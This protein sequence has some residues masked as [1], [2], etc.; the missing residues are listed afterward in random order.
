ML[1]NYTHLDFANIKKRSVHFAG[2][3]GWIGG[4]RLCIISASQ[5]HESCPWARAAFELAA[6]RPSNSR[7]D[8]RLQPLMKRFPSA[9]GVP[10]AVFVQFPYDLA[11][12]MR[13]P[14]P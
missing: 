2:D 4:F 1:L 3:F 13:K 9:I 10:K 11:Y 6:E 8:R 12:E 14:R 7:R 5:S